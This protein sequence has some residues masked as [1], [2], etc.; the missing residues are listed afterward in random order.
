M[1]IYKNLD[2]KE[3]I[4]EEMDDNHLLNSFAKNIRQKEPGI[5]GV[6]GPLAILR[7]EIMRRMAIT[8]QVEECLT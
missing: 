4:V 6:D 8:K 1:A 2:G 3:F 5:L 7:T